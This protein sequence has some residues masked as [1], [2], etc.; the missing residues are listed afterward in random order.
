MMLSSSPCTLSPAT[1]PLNRDRG[2]YSRGFSI[3]LGTTATRLPTTSDNIHTIFGEEPFMACKLRRG[4]LAGA[5]LGLLGTTGAQA[6]GFNIPEISIGG[7][8]TAN[9]VVANPRMLGA[10]PYNPSLAAFHSGTTLSG[11]MMVVRADSKVTTAPPNAVVSTKFQGRDNVFI[12][13]LSVTHQLNDQF[14]LAFS[15]SVPLGLSTDYP[16][17]TFSILG[18]AGSPTKSQVEVVDISPS[19]AFKVGS[20]TA[21]AVGIDYYWARKVAFDTGS[22]ANKGDG[23][24]WGWN[25]SASHVNG[26]WSLGAS[27]RSHA[28]ADISGTTSAGGFTFG[29]TRTTLDIPWRA[30]IGARYQV[31]SRLAVEADI[32]R[33]GWSS[34]DTLTIRHNAPAPIPNPITS[35]NHWKDANAYRLGATWQ[36]D[37]ATELRFGYTF[38]KTAMPTAYFS[39][40][41]ADADR[42][43]FSIGIERQLGDGLAIEAGYMYVKFKNRSLRSTTI[44][45]TDPNGTLAYNGDYKTTV[46][47][48]GLG[49]SKRF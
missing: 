49:L 27:F 22:V 19:M 9:A 18:A 42:H 30:Q 36:L 44:P 14:T 4:V 28:Q 15:T 6:S 34:F 5:I 37:E 13:N 40:R 12:P 1:E 32:S 21:V 43:L 3:S 24:G 23:D 33:T 7:L 45:T 47:L 39:A 17:N 8:G 20:S 38:D 25:I 35:T 10:V 48:F 46:H 31:D 2:C 26:P 11:G 29:G 41:T 16:V